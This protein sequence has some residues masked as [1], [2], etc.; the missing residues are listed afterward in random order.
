MHPD[1]LKKLAKHLDSLAL[2]DQE[3]IRREQE[4]LAIRKNA[5]AA[6]HESCAAFVREVN[7]AVTSV[8]LEMSP[9]ELNGPGFQESGPNVFQ[10]NV[11]GR[12]I[13]FLFQGTEPLLTTEN[14]RT[15]YT[16]EGSVRWF[17]QDMLERD[18]VKDHRLFCCIDR[19][20]SEWRFY[21]PRT[22][23]SGPVDDEYLA[24]LLEQLV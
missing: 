12:V 15:P 11:N 9:A 24:S 21:D 22:H 6:L 17:N 7:A 18:E 19:S 8:S 10:I 4:I 23:R 20:R 1:R 5:A 2:R 16:L 3:R 14:L 13:Q